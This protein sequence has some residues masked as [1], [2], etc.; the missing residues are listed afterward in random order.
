MLRNKAFLDAIASLDLGY[1]SKHV[2]VI[3]LF[4]ICNHCKMLSYLL[5]IWSYPS[6]GEF[7]HCHLAWLIQILSKLS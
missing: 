5:D 7:W 4:S 3:K 1:E 6:K 2:C